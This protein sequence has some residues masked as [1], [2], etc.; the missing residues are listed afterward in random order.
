MVP[1]HKEAASRNTECALTKLNDKI[2]IFANTLAFFM[3]T[4][5]TYTEKADQN[6]GREAIITVSARKKLVDFSLTPS[7]KDEA[8]AAFARRGD[9]PGMLACVDGTLV[10]IRK[11]GELNLAD[12]ARFMSRRGYYALNVMLVCNAELRILVV[13]ARFPE[14][15][16]DS[17]GPC[18]VA[19]LTHDALLGCCRPLRRDSKAGGALLYLMQ[20]LE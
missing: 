18:Q 4:F 6:F 2:E 17:W 10:A 9:I 19:D 12:T 15:C 5:K 11:P 3:E 20:C 14:S 7:A 16:H 13:D 8:N 1:S